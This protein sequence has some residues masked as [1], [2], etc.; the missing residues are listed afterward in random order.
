MDDV[1]DGKINFR[2]RQKNDLAFQG[3]ICLALLAL[4]VVLFMIIS[5]NK[6]T[7]QLGEQTFTYYT[8]A[9]TVKDVLQEVGVNG[10]FGLPKRPDA[11]AEGETISYLCVSETLAAT[12]QDDM[13]IQ[14]YR[15]SIKKSVEDITLAVP[16]R[17]KWD[18]F[19]GAGDERV[20]EPGKSGLMQNIFLSF[21]RD[22]E[23]M[24]KEK[25]HSRMIAEPL[26]RIIAS[27]SYAAVSRQGVKYS[28][29]PQRFEATAY[30]F[31]GYRTAVGASTR[32]G[33]VAVD[34]RVIPMGTQMF[35]KGYGYAVAADTGGAIKGRRV[36][37]F[38]ESNSDAKKWGR[39]PVDIYIL[40]KPE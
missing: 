26:T 7:V 34:P 32:R 31:T 36:D 22:G 23:L 5:V 3:F 18:I 19:M 14:I 12:V 8:F 28:G 37:L 1:K 20:V 39:R 29:R 11:V 27:G 16:V 33:I 2:S 35:I 30:S 9:P 4:T 13:V 25:I 17:R 21:Y 38:F 24:W 15:D 6:V 40:E 10:P